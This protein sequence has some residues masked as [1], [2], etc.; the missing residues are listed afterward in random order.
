[1][2]AP[3]RTTHATRR[4]RPD[5]RRAIATYAGLTTVLMLALLVPGV[6]SR[7]PD[8]LALVTPIGMW[9]PAVAAL[10]AGRRLR[11]GRTWRERMALTPLRPPGR[12]ARQLAAVFGAFAAVAVAT[13]LL[14][15]AVGVAPL[16]LADL[17]GYR[18][19]DPAL[20]LDE[21]RRQ[22]LL[23]TLALPLF[24]LGYVAL[25]LGEEVGWRG[26]AQTTLA[27]WGFW[28]A[29]VAIAA[30]WGVWHV[31]LVAAYALAGEASWWEVPIIAVNLTL[32][33]AALSVVRALTGSVW[34]AAFGH[35][36]LNTVFVF[37]YSAPV[38]AGARDAVPAQLG[39]AAVGGVV[40]ALALALA[41]PWV[42]RAAAVPQR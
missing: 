38:L 15:H 33:G 18:A 41:A 26:F 5:E 22:M 14:G 12:L 34:P 21:A 36:V 29:T 8:L 4:L 35:A 3:D 11:D 7:N 28:R 16:D 25:T 39:F 2:A 23:T 13:L 6:V 32:G 24:A 1:M 20:G 30:F 17:S 31:P 19:A 40:W 42:R 10:V 27:P 37:A 9:V